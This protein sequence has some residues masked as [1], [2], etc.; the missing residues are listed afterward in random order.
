MRPGKIQF[1]TIGTIPV[2]LVACR[3]CNSVGM[4]SEFTVCSTPGRWRSNAL[5]LLAPILKDQDAEL[6]RVETDYA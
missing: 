3:S 4:W 5:P 1:E 2:G 6:A